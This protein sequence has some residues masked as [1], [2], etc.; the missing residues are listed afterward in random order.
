M[1]NDQHLFSVVLFLDMR[2]FLQQCLHIALSYHLSS[3]LLLVYSSKDRLSLPEFS[4]VGM[5][6]SPCRLNHSSCPFQQV[7]LKAPQQTIK[8]EF[9]DNKM[10]E[11]AL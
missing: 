11:Y 2:H 8:K 3:V 9:Y 4:R 1:S 5:M 6:L 7:L 10:A